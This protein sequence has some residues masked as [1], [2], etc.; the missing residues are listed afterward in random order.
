MF[1][2]QETD[3]V[4]AIFFRHGLSVCFIINTHGVTDL[5]N[6]CLKQAR[7]MSPLV[8]EQ[9]KVV[10]CEYLSFTTKALSTIP[11]YFLK[12]S[13]S[14]GHIMLLSSLV[15]VVLLHKM[16]VRLLLLLLLQMMMVHCHGHLMLLLLPVNVIHVV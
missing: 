6:A 9:H 11:K 1:R 12:K 16:V 14:A 4:A 3:K 15:M 7:P 13:A 10:I 5:K 2:T 8:A